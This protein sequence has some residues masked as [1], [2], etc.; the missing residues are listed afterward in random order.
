MID[1]K[2]TS[3]KKELEQILELQQRNL[4]KNLS[5]EEMQT[6]GFVTVEHNYDIL[7]Q[8]HEV[9][10]HVIAVADGNVVGYVLSM[11][12]SF[13]NSIPVLVPMFKELEK[14]DIDPNYIVM[15]QVCVDKNYRGKGIFRGLYAKMKAVFTDDF[16][17]I[18]TEIDALNTR[19]LN[20]HEAVGFSEICEY[21]AGGQLWKVV[22]M[23]I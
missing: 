22:A 18:I 14:I 21:E 9:H 3:S 13:G 1:F 23:D 5:E 4:P 11:S 10:P 8:M 20:A 7:Y 16:K 6:Q 15:G 12:K 19:S 17:S 2:V